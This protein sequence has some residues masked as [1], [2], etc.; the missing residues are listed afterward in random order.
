MEDNDTHLPLR[1]LSG[2]FP[3]IE[4][5]DEDDTEDH[6]MDDYDLH[7]RGSLSS[8]D[9]KFRLS[10]VSCSKSAS[11]EEWWI[12]DA[13]HRLHSLSLDQHMHRSMAFFNLDSLVFHP[14]QK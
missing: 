14:K 3:C 8:F 7:H 4:W 13:S 9:D 5:N 10:P 6:S 2:P 11:N 1:K 12:G